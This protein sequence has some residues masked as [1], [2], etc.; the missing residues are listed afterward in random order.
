MEITSLVKT[1]AVDS[2]AYKKTFSENRIG[3]YLVVLV[4]YAMKTSHFLH[5]S[6]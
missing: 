6:S 4:L 1:D 2:T 5:K 3:K